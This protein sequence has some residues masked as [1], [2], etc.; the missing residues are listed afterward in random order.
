MSLV[1]V[2]KGPVA[3]AGSTPNFFNIT[4]IEAPTTVAKIIIPNRADEII[5][6]NF[7]ETESKNKSEA[8]IKTALQTSPFT[9]E[10]KNS[11][12]IFLKVSLIQISPMLK[13]R[14]ITIAAC[15]PEFPPTAITTGIKKVASTNL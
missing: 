13:P 7:K 10:T 15:V 11:L 1:V 4:G 9:R 5:T 2:T 3:I 12:N 8:P 14:T 6:A